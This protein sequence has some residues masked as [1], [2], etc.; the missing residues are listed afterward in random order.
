MNRTIAVLAWIIILVSASIVVISVVED[1]DRPSVEINEGLMQV[2]EFDLT[3]PYG[4]GSTAKGTIFFIDEGEDIRVR[5]VADVNIIPGDYG[6]YLL[7]GY[8]YLS[9]AEVVSG[10]NGDT[11]GQ[12]IDCSPGGPRFSIDRAPGS[13]QSKGGTGTIIVDYITNSNF[14]DDVHKLSICVQIGQY[15]ETYSCTV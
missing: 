2:T 12:L 6:G 9:P 1:R 11:S 10:Y 3:D 15:F 14:T 5:V 4:L 7:H 13:T 8:D